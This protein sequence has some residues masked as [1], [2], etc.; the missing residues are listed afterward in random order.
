MNKI[1][2]I[3]GALLLLFSSC[4]GQ[5]KIKKETNYKDDKFEVGQVWNYEARLGEEGSTVQIVKID[6]YEGQ[7]AFIH[8]AV[9]GLE[10]KNPAVESGI[11]ETISHLPFSRTSFAESI[12]E[13]VDAKAALSDYEEGYNEW[14]AAFEAEEGGVFAISIAEAVNYIESTL[15]Q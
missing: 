5:Q 6:K 3:I 10:V 9:S 8:V 4:A 2:L 7:E 13:L 12:T 1:R 15:N 14:R 11:S